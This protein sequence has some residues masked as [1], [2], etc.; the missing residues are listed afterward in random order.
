MFLVVM[1]SGVVPASGRAADMGSK[2]ELMEGYAFGD[3]RGGVLFYENLVNHRAVGK[4][5]I[6]DAEYAAMCGDGSCEASWCPGEAMDWVAIRNI[7]SNRVMVVSGTAQVQWK[8]I[9]PFEVRSP[10]SVSRDGK[11]IAVIGRQN[12]IDSIWHVNEQGARPVWTLDNVMSSERLQSGWKA[13]ALI[14]VVSDGEW[15]LLCDVLAEPGC[16]RLFRGYLSSVSPDG[17]LVAVMSGQNTVAVYDIEGSAAVVRLSARMGWAHDAPKWSPDSRLLVLNEMT[18]RGSRVAI[19]DVIKKDKRHGRQT[20][21]KS[22]SRMGVV[23]VP[24]A[25]FRQ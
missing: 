2:K 11:T 17:K 16:R 14:N 7:Q 20:Y 5:P 4:Y 10:L 8:T 13:A 6:P 12:S 23:Q 9:L 24:T 15:T 25:S 1:L 3:F 19:V 18:S 22:M 21:G